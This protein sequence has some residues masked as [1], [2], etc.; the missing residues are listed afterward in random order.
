MRKSMKRKILFA[1]A[2]IAAL[3]VGAAELPKF[4]TAAGDF[5]EGAPMWHI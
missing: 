5:R 3:A 2:T 4:A 1:M